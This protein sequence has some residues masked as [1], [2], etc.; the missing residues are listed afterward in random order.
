M[1][2]LPEV[3]TIRRSLDPLIR[4]HRIVS[5]QV[6]QR[7]LRIPVVEDFERRL[8]GKTVRGVKRK[9]KYLLVE[10][11]PEDVWVLHLGMSG[12]LTC[13]RKPCP[14]VKHDHMVV[15]FET[16]RELRYHDPRRFGLSLVLR[17]EE[18]SQ[19]RPLSHLG[20]D[21]LSVQFNADY[22]YSAMRNSKRRIKD[23]LMDQTV[24]AGLGNI[25]TNEILFRTG[26]RPT[27]RVGRINHRLAK[28]IVEATPIVLEEA[29]RWRGTSFSNYR[30]GENQKGEFQNHLQ[31]YNREGENCRVCP[32]KIKKL[33]VGN[34]SVF[35]CSTCQT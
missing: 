20:V 35:Y 19:W 11:D 25:Y 28:R 31:V 26:L 16:G 27:R 10:L 18:L 32:D 33:Q 8:E 9:G 21:P 3:E 24:V 4:G 1:P 14:I 34:R 7:Q 29:I 2:E 13:L 17:N 22:L 30:D 6:L 12:K 5:V 23:L 15:R